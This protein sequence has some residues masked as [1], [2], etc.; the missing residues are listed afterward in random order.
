MS[1]REDPAGIFGYKTSETGN[2]FSASIGPSPSLCV[3]L[4]NFIFIQRDTDKEEPEGIVPGLGNERP[5]QPEQVPETFEAGP[6]AEG[7]F[8][9]GP[10]A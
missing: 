10:F 8:E 4:G 2:I 1:G 3:V 9:A 5:G 6:I 7:P